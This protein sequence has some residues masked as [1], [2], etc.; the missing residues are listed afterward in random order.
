MAKAKKTKGDGKVTPLMQQYFKV[1]SKH[2]DAILLFRVGDFYETFGEDAITA[3]QVLGIVQTK[4][5][6]GGSDIELAGF[7]YHSMDLYLPR[8]VRAGYRVA[9]CEQLEKPSPQKKI[10]RRGV[11]EIVTP[12]VAVDDKLLDHKSNNFLASLY[13]GKK[14][15]VGVSFL[16]VSTGE[17]MVCEGSLTYA[18]KLIQS[19]KPSEVLFPKDRQKDFLKQFGDKLYTFMLDEWVYTFDYAR[20]KLLEHFEVQ[21]LKGFGV[22]EMELGQVAAGATLH[23]LATTENKNLQHINAISRLQPDRYVWLDRFTIRNLELVYS[24]HET[25]VALIDVLDQ[26]VSPMGARLLKKWVVLP[27]TIPSA[28][29]NRLNIVDH[30]YKDTELEGALTQYIQQIGDLERLISKVPLGKINPREIKQVQRALELIRPIKE[31]LQN[32]NLEQLAKIG[33]GLNPCALLRDEIEKRLIDDPPVNLSK[34][35]VMADG[36]NEE[37]DELRNIVNNSKDLLLGIQQRE[38]ENT[39][40]S[41]LK[42]GFNNVFGYYLEV[43]NKHKNKVP[44]EWMRKQ[45]LTNSERYITDELKQLESKILG[46]E[47]KILALEEKLFSELVFT[48]ADYIQPI[49][50]NAALIARIDCLLGFAK[51]ARKQNYCRPEINDGTVIDIKQGR[52]PVIEQQLSI[53]EPY[54]PN[55][56]YLDTE[57]QQVMMIT[58]PNMAGKSALLRQTAL[59]GLMA[60]MGSFV[61]AEKASI[62]LIDKVFTRVGASDNISSGE[63]TFMVEM[64]ETASI[65]NNISDRSLIL[66]DEIGRGTSTY[67]GISIAWSI[68]EF[69]HNNGTARPKTL[70]ATHYHELNELANKFERIKNFNIATREVGQKVIFL[71]KLVPGGSQH[72]FG[73]HVAKMAGMP[74]TIVERAAHI[75]TQLEQKSINNED[76]SNGA[77]TAAKPDTGRI[78]TETLQL[79]IFETVDPTAGK[80]KEALTDLNINNMTP[81]ECMMKLNELKGLLEE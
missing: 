78:S 61:P 43:T 65:M 5:N 4:R 75:L 9:I 34:G 77:I 46:A 56:V 63:S 58:G 48:L 15:H 6:N 71:R 74:R 12:G 47:E 80:I 1:K 19:F 17:F 38:V 57:T 45:T 29:D 79:S 81:I 76:N 32:S 27:L 24:N 18:D 25:G 37:L 31:T 42:I 62:G 72:S 40:I 21:N 52:H 10:V 35:G 8:L 39:S 70:F 23:Y 69:L 44:K 26:T 36:F 30:F 7:P 51:V 3:S 73:I 66:L 53:D 16:D 33:E 14:D 49:Q 55:D 68:A 11:T 67:D 60:Q 54:V 20:E 28:I 13:F 59:I 41:S 22:E 2:P 64:N 50:H